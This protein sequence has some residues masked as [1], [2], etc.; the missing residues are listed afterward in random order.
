MAGAS[1]APHLLATPKAL[2]DS[3]FCSLPKKAILDSTWLSR[4]LEHVFTLAMAA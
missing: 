2:S 3:R 4:V 1:L